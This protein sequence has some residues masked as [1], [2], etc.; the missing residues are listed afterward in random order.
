MSFILFLTK[1]FLDLTFPD[2]TQF[3]ATWES[4]NILIFS[5]ENR[6]ISRILSKHFIDRKIESSSRVGSVLVFRARKAKAYSQW[7][8]THTQ[9]THK[10]GRMRRKIY[11]NR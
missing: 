8:A 1:T 9:Q 10:L 5:I 6:S 2:K 7:N 11:S 4:E 3:N